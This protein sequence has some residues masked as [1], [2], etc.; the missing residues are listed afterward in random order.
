MEFNFTV[1][2]QQIE[3]AGSSFAN[4]ES[5]YWLYSTIAQT[6]IALIAFA[7]VVVI[8]KVQGLESEI[9]SIFEMPGDFGKIMPLYTAIYSE[10]R[11]F[12]N[13]EI[14]KINNPIFDLYQLV[15]KIDDFNPDKMPIYT[16]KLEDI[17]KLHG[18]EI[19]IWSNYKRLCVFS[20]IT[21]FLSLLF[22][23]LIPLAIKMP[24]YS[25]IVFVVLSLIWCCLV[26]MVGYHNIKD[27]FTVTKKTDKN[28][29]EISE[30]H[31]KKILTKMKREKTTSR[32]GLMI[33]VCRNSW[34][35]M[36]RSN[37]C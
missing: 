14:I 12:E 9:K 34:E 19:T 11:Y 7:G 37:K 6:Y 24:A 25:L 22:L 3:S 27:L 1:I 36:K 29:R 35:N 8:T 5:L 31:I 20:L 4:K 30:S 33:N 28:Y 21:V 18:L 32:I 13:K 17:K 15:T 23:A 2:C 26:F 10:E 16:C